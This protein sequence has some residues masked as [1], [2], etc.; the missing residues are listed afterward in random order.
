MRLACEILLRFESQAEDP[1][2]LDFDLLTCSEM[3]WR[4]QQPCGY[5]MGFTPGLSMFP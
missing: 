4:S 2:G 5:G 3:L 1:D